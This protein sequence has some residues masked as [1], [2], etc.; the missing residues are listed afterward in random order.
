MMLDLATTTQTLS[1]SRQRA[2]LSFVK[3]GRMTLSQSVKFCPSA[4]GNISRRLSRK[5]PKRKTGL[6]SF[7]DSRPTK[8][9]KIISKK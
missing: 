8:F 4:A 1:H 5:R 2:R 3:I 9:P 7:R 6:N